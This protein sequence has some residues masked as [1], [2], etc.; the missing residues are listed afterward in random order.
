MTLVT[1][2]I[3]DP[4]EANWET[5]EIQ[6]II[7]S[8]AYED[9]NGRYRE[10]YLTKTGDQ[11]ESVIVK[12]EEHVKKLRRFSIDPEY[13]RHFVGNGK[14]RFDLNAYFHMENPTSK[15]AYLNLCSSLQLFGGQETAFK[16]YL[17]LLGKDTA[18]VAQRTD[19]ELQTLVTPDLERVNQLGIGRILVEKSPTGLRAITAPSKK[20]LSL[21][22]DL[23]N[24]SPFERRTIRELCRAGLFVNIAKTF[25]VRFSQALRRDLLS[26]AEFVIRQETNR[27]KARLAN[28]TARVTDLRKH[29]G[30]N[31]SKAFCLDP[32]SVHDGKRLGDHW[33]YAAWREWQSK[34]KSKG[35][36]LNAQVAEA[37]KRIGSK[38]HTAICKL[39]ASSPH[40]LVFDL[41][42]FRRTH[43]ET[44]FRILTAVH[45][46]YPLVFDST[47]GSAGK[48]EH[49]AYIQKQR[50]EALFD[51]CK[52]CHE[53]VLQGHDDFFPQD[54]K[55]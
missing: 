31:L 44:F 16:T 6:S 47:L 25:V 40:Q 4:V 36:V 5:V 52:Q 10:R 17:M 2:A 55:I 46:L 20:P 39:H 48:L 26:Y 34:Q 53:A 8:F 22:P 3:Y 45:K 54:L 1:N 9:E 24:F 33:H 38:V 30:S 51:Y 23:K 19:G 28:K 41:A 35:Y 27:A 42:E 32:D 14:V 49:T 18:Y 37:S 43:Q 21:A 50:D 15:R 29:V 11:G 13:Y 7:S 12:S